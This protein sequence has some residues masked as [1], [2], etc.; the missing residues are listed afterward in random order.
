MRLEQRLAGGFAVLAVLLA[1]AG[2]WHGVFQFDDYNAI[3]L[4]ESVHS[5]A[6]WWQHLGDGLRPLLKLSYLLNWTIDPQPR[7]FHLFN[8]AVHLACSLMVYLLARKFGETVRPESDWQAI[9]WVT[10]LLF[11]LHPAHTEAVTY[12]SGRATSLMTLF[13]LSA[14]WL[15]ACGRRL[16]SLL[17]FVLALLVKES[18]ILL[19]VCLLLWEYLVGSSWRLMLRRLWPWLAIGLLA[20]ALVLVHPGYRTMLLDSW[21]Q[22]S[23]ATAVW[24]QAYAAAWLLGQWAWPVALNIDPDLPVIAD[25]AAVWPQLL[26]LVVLVLI[27]AVARRRRPWLSLG[28]C[29]AVLHLF[30]FNAVFSRVDIANER[31]LYWGDWALIF[32]FVA[33]LYSALPRRAFFVIAL[34]LAGALGVLSFSRNRVYESEIALWQDTAAKSPHKARVLNN[35]GFALAE[36]GRPDEARA[37]YEEALRWQPDYIKASNNLDRLA[38]AGQ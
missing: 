13:Y 23:W 8:L 36:A 15:H 3:V 38:P 16:W 9:A 34:V 17:L 12:L 6:A 30:I 24:T 18:A 37:A 10:A 29:W 28:L 32:A 2:S 11:A 19:P 21:S 7:G 33:E 35:L 31:L 20:T 5:L 25:A 22:H 14:L 4:V 26:G 27:A 1:Y